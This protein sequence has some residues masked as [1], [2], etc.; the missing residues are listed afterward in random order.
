[1]DSYSRLNPPLRPLDFSGRRI[2]KTPGS[3]LNKSRMN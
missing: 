1:M 2:L 3:F